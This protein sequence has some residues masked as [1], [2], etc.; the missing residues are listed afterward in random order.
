MSTRPRIERLRRVLLA[1]IAEYV[2]TN[3]GVLDPAGAEPPF[4]YT[5]GLPAHIGHPE[6][7]ICGIPSE[8][9]IGVI[10]AVVSLLR[11]TPALEGRVTGA[12]ER[13]MPLWIAS[14]PRPMTEKYLTGAA[15]WREEHYDGQP[16]TAQQVIIP[17]KAALF[18]WQPG[19]EPG[20]GRAQSLLLPE[21]PIRQPELRGVHA[22]R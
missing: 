11:T 16:A 20:Y 13:D 6:L 4:T 3:Q 7:V 10:A 5:I 19:C 9:A 15:W 18:P 12:L 8:S 1:R 17:D 22:R 14:V 21:L 2:Y